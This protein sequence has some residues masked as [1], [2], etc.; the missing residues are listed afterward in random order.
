MAPSLVR[1]GLLMAWMFCKIGAGAAVSE[2]M[3][4]KAVRRRTGTV[5]C[6]PPVEGGSQVIRAA[7][8]TARIHA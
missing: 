3:R 2:M 8:R 6:A 5:T 1:F 4:Y 7:V